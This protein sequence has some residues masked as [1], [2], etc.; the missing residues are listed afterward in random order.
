MK[1]QKNP[2]KNQQTETKPMTV[3][4]KPRLR[5]VQ[6]E[7]QTEN[8]Q[9]YADEIF[10][11]DVVFGLGPAGTGKTFVALTCACNMFQ[12][13]QIKQIII[14]RPNVSSGEKSL[15]FFK[16]TKE[17]K[18]E[19]WMRPALKILYRHFGKDAVDFYREA[20]QILLE[21]LETMRG[22]TF[23]DAFVLLDEAQN[24]TFAD[25]EMFLTR[26]GQNSTVVVDG[27]IEQT[28]LHDRSGLR[29][30]LEMVDGEFPVI[31][32]DIEDIV[33][34]ALTKRF[35]KLFRAYRKDHNVPA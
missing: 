15:G 6:F 21:P 25:L 14:T 29:H 27:D 30:V 17:E 22:E 8:Q 2:P 19:E 33:R 26:I 34:S 18:I 5:Q 28:D 11:N 20:G 13:K 4:R 9:T 1:R 35:V 31:E 10:D 32:F 3:R 24:T 16:G 23:D 7:A 12:M